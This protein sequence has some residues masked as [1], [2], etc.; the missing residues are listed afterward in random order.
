MQRIERAGMVEIR[1]EAIKRPIET[2]QLLQQI[3]AKKLNDP[4]F[5]KELATARDA[6]SNA[7]AGVQM[8]ADSLGINRRDAAP[9]HPSERQ[10]DVLVGCHQCARNLSHRR[11]V[12][13]LRQ[14]N[15][16]GIVS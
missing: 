12:T 8:E 10:S 9:A 11:P 16:T 6:L 7:M 5:N 4:R 15:P 13:A 14:S 3:A 2:G 1:R